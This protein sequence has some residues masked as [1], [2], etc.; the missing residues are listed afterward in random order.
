M[1]IVEKLQTGMRIAHELAL[2]AKGECPE[3]LD[4]K[5]TLDVLTTGNISISRYGDGE[6]NLIAGKALKFQA[7]D[8]RLQERLSTILSAHEGGFHR[9]AIPYALCSVR[10]LSLR[11][12]KFWL[13]HCN[14]VRE[15]VYPLLDFER[16][17]LDAQVSR[18]YVNRKDKTQSKFYLDA[19]RSL[20]NE[21]RIL[22]VEGAET[23][24]G[25]GNDLLDGAA[26]IGRVI[27]PAVDAWSSYQDIFD[28]VLERSRTFDLVLLALGP[29]ATVLAY[30]LSLNGVRAID[31]GN[32]DMEYEWMQ[33]GSRSQVAIEGK[34]TLEAEGGTRV[35]AFE[36]ARYER[37]IMEIIS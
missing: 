2:R 23:R 15:T 14:E 11:S 17:Y 35:T 12:S 19:W 30:D 3:V 20:W 10:G 36:D 24:F 29:T 33:R 13:Y 1:A 7:F 34:Y 5:S 9:V 22:I 26:S 31:S 25:A 16:Q 27:C 32:L 4:T 18:F 6:F 28:S 8:Y 21:K 37:Q